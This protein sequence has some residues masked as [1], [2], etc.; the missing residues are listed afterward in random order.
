M[1]TIKSIFVLALVV[2]KVTCFSVTTISTRTNGRGR[3]ITHAAAINEE[4]ATDAP[5]SMTNSIIMPLSYEEMIREASAAVKDAYEKK[6]TKQIVR[7]LL[8][9]DASSSDLGV[10]NE[11]TV[12]VESQ[13]IVLVPPDESWQGGI[14]QLYRSAAPTCT[15][16]LRLF[17]REDSGVP[18]RIVE[19]RSV[20]ESGVDGVG[21]LTADFGSET[22]SCF[23]QP[24]QET[25]EDY[26]QSTVQKESGLVLLMNPQWRLTDDVFDKASKDG[27]FF[28][29]VASFLGG[30]GGTLKLLDEMGF[31]PVYTFEGYVCRG[32]NVRIIKR[33][34]SDWVAFCEKE[35]NNYENVGTTE[36]RPTYQQVEQMLID[37][38]Y[39]FKY[40]QDMGI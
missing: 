19:D 39:G 2:S 36:G 7:V 28:G 30:K 11:G 26:V 16:I 10:I 33:F 5:V 12:D 9:R 37:R 40:A 8:P 15:E 27:G 17:T 6:I 13:N 20:D 34:D 29:S 35:S 31:T 14:M 23:V 4:E 22:A 21:L 25:I 38:G 24:S 32:Y 1:M 18:P 3:M